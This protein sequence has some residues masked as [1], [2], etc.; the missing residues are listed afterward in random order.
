MSSREELLEH[1]AN[2]CELLEP[3][4]NSLPLTLVTYIDDCLNTATVTDFSHCQFLAILHKAKLGDFSMLS[5][6]TLSSN[7]KMSEKDL[8]R[9]INRNRKLTP[10]QIEIIKNKKK[11]TMD[12]CI[13]KLPLFPGNFLKLKL[14]FVK[15]SK[16][17]IEPQTDLNNENFEAKKI[18]TFVK[19]WGNP[20]N[21]KSMRHRLMEEAK[22]VQK[23]M[24]NER[25]VS[26]SIF[27]FNI[28]Y[29]VIHTHS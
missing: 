28:I 3:L 12:T 25:A 16:G 2:L 18:G 14:N 9:E 22:A 6:V 8:Q 10:H 29:P 21:I 1:R 27:Y 20:S 7:S 19:V 26:Y 17:L 4:R 13:I 24:D 15:E 11:K 5:R 23:R